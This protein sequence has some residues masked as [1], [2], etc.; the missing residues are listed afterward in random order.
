LQR[1]VAQYHLKKANQAPNLKR[2][3]RM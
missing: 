1:K 3:A 2:K